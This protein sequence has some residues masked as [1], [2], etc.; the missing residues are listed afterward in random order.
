MREMIVTQAAVFAVETYREMRRQFDACKAEGRPLVALLKG[1]PVHAN[2]F[3][4]VRG[5]W[6][7]DLCI[8]YIDAPRSWLEAVPQTAE[9]I[10]PVES[11]VPIIP[12]FG[13]LD[14]EAVNMVCDLAAWSVISSERA[15]L[16]LLEGGADGGEGGTRRAAGPAPEKMD[17][18]R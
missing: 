6:A 11:E 4:G 14:N 15:F 18:C 3:H 7:V 2:P 13:L 10:K 9:V 5:G 12:A 16:S 17:R 8:W 1:V